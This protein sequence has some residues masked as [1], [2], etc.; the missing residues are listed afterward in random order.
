MM[1]QIGLSSLIAAVASLGLA[2]L[3]PAQQPTKPEPA[4]QDTAQLS[5]ATVQSVRTALA[6]AKPA[7]VDT[8]VMQFTGTF[9]DL[10]KRFEEFTKTFEAQGLSKRKF[11]SNPQ[12][13]F[14]VYED[15]E[16]KSSYK[17][18][19]GVQVPNKVDVKDPL[20]VETFEV[21]AAARVRHTGSY[22]MLGQVRNAVDKE[23]QGGKG[24]K[25]AAAP[26]RRAGFPVLARLLND[27]RK[28]PDNQRRTE[29]IIPVER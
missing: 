10:P 17:L 4:A 6:S 16:G 19:V 27:P 8:V 7:R 3:P 1:I 13:I 9:D 5:R 14:V 28:V 25:A 22:K 15:P 20:R 18:G 2:V 26:A 12:G 11:P 29:L 23:A 24:P 21:K